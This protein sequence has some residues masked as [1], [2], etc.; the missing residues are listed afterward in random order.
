MSE[1]SIPVQGQSNWSLKR[2]AV[3]FVPLVLLIGVVVLFLSTGAGLQTPTAL[4]PIEQ[5]DVQRILL[6]QPDLIVVEIVNSGPDAVTIAQVLV[7]EAYWQFD[8]EPGATLPRFGAA[9]IRIPYPWV[10]DEA[11]EIG[12]ITNTGV[13]FDAAIELAVQT[14]VFDVNTFL[15]FAL[16]GFYVGVVPISLGLMWHPFMRTLKRRIL[17][18][19]LALTLGLL[20]FL[21]IDTVSEGLE[22][23]GL[24]PGAFNGL[25]LF[26]AGA[27]LA[28]LAIQLVSSRSGA[29]R[30]TEQGRLSLS[31]LLAIGIGLHNLA[32]GL[33]IGAAYAIGEAALGAFLVVGFTLHNIT[34]GIGIAAPVAKDRP[35]LRT[36]IKLALISGAPAIVGTWI[37]GFI[38]SDVA[39]AIFLGVGSGA[40]VQVIVEVGKLLMQHGKREGVSYA[41]W[42][43]VIGFT[44]GLAI[45]YVTALL[46]SV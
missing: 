15:Q 35:A 7:D 10:Q 18:A 39:A 12:L 24:V 17:D 42:P 30:D 14:P 27:L 46:V 23:A 6:P 43:N 44:A 16:I 26:S 34:E 8:I 22:V 9:T 40:I 19:I 38:Y 29:N 36:F 32:E 2:V 33:A 31:Y 21:L 13:T 28:Y 11:H 5:I 4:P 1:G 41:T 45:M 3:A 37:G 25:I 20:V